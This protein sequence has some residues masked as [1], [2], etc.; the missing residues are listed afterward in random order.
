MVKSIVCVSVVWHIISLLTM[1]EL[2]QSMINSVSMT[3]ISVM[4]E[5]FIMIVTD[6]TV[7]SQV[8]MLVGISG[9]KTEIIMMRHVV[10]MIV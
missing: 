10:M 6:F 3:E 9:A 5:I 8:I 4:R 1:S 7:M 2:I